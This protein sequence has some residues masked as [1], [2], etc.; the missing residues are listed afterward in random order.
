VP[1][2]IIAPTR[3][4]SFGPQLGVTYS[5]V[6]MPGAPVADAWGLTRVGSLSHGID[7]SASW[8]HRAMAGAPGWSRVGGGQL[9]PTVAMRHVR[10]RLDA[11][12]A[13]VGLGGL[14][15]AVA[16]V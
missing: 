12:N 7:V 11:G 3:T 4:T 10:W 16:G 6:P 14:V 13:A 15:R 1:V 2:Q 9:F 5:A 8:T